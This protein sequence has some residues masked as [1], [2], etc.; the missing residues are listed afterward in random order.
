MMNAIKVSKFGDPSVLE[1]VQTEMIKP[2]ENEVLIKV[3]G[4]GIN[5]LDTYIRSGLFAPEMLPTLPYTPGGDI[6][7]IVVECGSN[8]KEFKTGD[9][10]YT[11]LKTSS[12]GYAEY[13]TS[14]SDFT[15][16]LPSNISP[17]EGCALGV[18]Y[19]TAY[20]ALVTIGQARLSKNF[21]SKSCFAQTWHIN[22]ITVVN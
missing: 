1:L 7:G 17:V 16:K 4:A 6:G 19:F 5:P 18:P 3:A 20:R 13:A 9:Q 21:G 10:V 14:E 22:L 11:V 8:V 15:F 12:G 2:A